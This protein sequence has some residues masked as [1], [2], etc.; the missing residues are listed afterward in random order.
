LVDGPVDDDG[1]RSV[2]HTIASGA[3][4]VMLHPRSRPNL[5]VVDGGRTPTNSTSSPNSCAPLRSSSASS[6]APTGAGARTA[7]MALRKENIRFMGHH[8]PGATA[9]QQDRRRERRPAKPPSGASN[10]RGSPV[11]SD[12]RRHRRG[13]LQIMDTLPDVV[14]W[15]ETL[16]DKQQTDWAAPTT[17]FQHCPVFNT[18]QLTTPTLRSRRQ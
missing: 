3:R 5:V 8:R 4:P 7:I 13:L 16:T 17:I 11:S 10:G 2:L 14:A 1:V 15:H 9:S 6:S 12:R 18:P